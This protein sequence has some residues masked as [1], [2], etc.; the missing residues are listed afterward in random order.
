M[1]RFLL[2]GAAALGMITSAALAQ[3]MGTTSTQ[4]TTT[5]TTPAMTAPVTV[6]NS[7]SAGSA[8]EADGRKTL[9]LGSSA[10]DSSGNSTSTTNTTTSYPLSNLITTTHKT[11]TMVNGVPK[12]TITTTQAYPGATTP[13]DVSTATK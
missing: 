10:T 9:K 13:P 6:A 5:T 1:T 2:A 12:E 11:T 8:L 4:Q 3:T 7:V